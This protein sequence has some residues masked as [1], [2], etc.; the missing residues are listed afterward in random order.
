MAWGGSPRSSGQQVTAIEVVTD[1]DDQTT[2]GRRPLADHLTTNSEPLSRALYSVACPQVQEPCGD[3]RPGEEG[4]AVAEIRRRAGGS[5]RT[6]LEQ[7]IW[8]G[9]W[10]YEEL[11]ARF[12]R[13]AREHREPATISVRHLQ[14]LASRSPLWRHAGHAPSLEI[15]IRLLDGAADRCT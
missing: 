3:P 14:R 1:H 9:D 15:A 10:T 11:T 8:Q 7:L 6:L 13:L 12:D 5:P 2:T 4:A